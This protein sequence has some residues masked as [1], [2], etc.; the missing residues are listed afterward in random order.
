[1]NDVKVSIV[2]V[3]F[4]SEKTIRRCMESVIAQT[5]KNIEYIVIDG[6]STDNTMEIVKEIAELNKNKIKWISEPDDGI[7]FAMNKG[8]AMAT[9]DVI[10]LLNSDDTY[11][12]DAVEKIVNSMT[13]SKYQILHGFE[14]DY[15]DGQMRSIH[16]VSH[17]VL[18]EEMINHVTCF[19]SSNIYKDFGMFDTQYISVADFDFMRRMK[20]NPQVE[21]VMVNS[22]ITNFY[23]GGMSQTHEAFLDLLKMQKNYGEIQKWKYIYHI[24]IYRLICIKKRLKMG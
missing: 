16:F 14:R 10:G 13:D 18:P 9:G 4:N 1:M 5:Y 20:S 22:I 17:E 8:I 3:C 12:T 24:I 19:V 7:Y 6:K 2:T 11:E 21:F 15:K 23:Y